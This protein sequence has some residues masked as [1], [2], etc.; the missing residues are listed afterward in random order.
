MMFFNFILAMAKGKK[1]QDSWCKRGLFSISQNLERKTDRL[2]NQLFPPLGEPLNI[3]SLGLGKKESFLD[4]LSDE[5]NYCNLALVYFKEKAHEKGESD[6]F[7]SF[8][9]DQMDFIL[10]NLLTED[11][12]TKLDEIILNLDGL[13]DSIKDGDYNNTH[14]ELQNFFGIKKGK[15]SNG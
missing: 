6:L 5:S 2:Q 13:R 9:K 14:L 7:D 11:I 4:T 10:S 3:E 1:Y 12:V 15:L 8:V